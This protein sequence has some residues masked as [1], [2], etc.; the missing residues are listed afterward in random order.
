MSEQRATLAAL[1]TSG[2]RPKENSCFTFAERTED[3]KRCS[4]TG[5]DSSANSRPFFAFAFR[6]AD[7]IEFSLGHRFANQD[8]P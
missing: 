4:T 1:P 6:L 5:A 3:H 7:V 2:K 8:H